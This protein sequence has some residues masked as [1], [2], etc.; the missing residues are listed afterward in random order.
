MKITTTILHKHIDD[1]K[2]VKRIM[3][4]ATL[5]LGI[6]TTTS[7]GRDIQGRIGSYMS[8]ELEDWIEAQ[9]E[10]ILRARHD[11]VNN[12]KL[13]LRTVEALAVEIGREDAKA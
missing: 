9:K 1:K 10:Y 5:E 11:R 12:A 4:R 8:F 13:L 7:M 6:K 3:D 2:V